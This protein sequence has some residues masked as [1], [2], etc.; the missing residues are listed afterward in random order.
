MFAYARKNLELAKKG[1]LTLSQ[2]AFKSLVQIPLSLAE[3]TISALEG[4]QPKLTRR[5]VQ[6]IIK[7]V[8]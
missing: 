1:I 3:A 7:Q 5:Q 2:A 8:G 6:A 4:G